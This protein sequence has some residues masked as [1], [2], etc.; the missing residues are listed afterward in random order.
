M[1]ILSEEAL[2][3]S[4]I[5]IGI[6]HI[7]EGSS[8]RRRRHQAQAEAGHLQSGRQHHLL[9]FHWTKRIGCMKMLIITTIIIL[10]LRIRVIPP[11]WLP[12]PL[13]LLP[14]PTETPPSLLLTPSLITPPPHLILPILFFFYQGGG[15]EQGLLSR[16]HIYENVERNAAAAAAAR[17]LGYSC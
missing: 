2:I 6:W 5:S 4:K 10:I 3:I 8:S 14:L 13:E 17:V 16:V 12:K 15:T 11:L 9:L 1:E 7:E